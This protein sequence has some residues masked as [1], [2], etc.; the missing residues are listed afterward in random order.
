MFPVLALCELV[1][2]PLSVN[3]NVGVGSAIDLAGKREER[4]QRRAGQER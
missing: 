3:S 2:D 4:A 1:R